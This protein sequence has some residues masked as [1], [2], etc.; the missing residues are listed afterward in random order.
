[1][2]A[3]AIRSA[4]PVARAPAFRSAPSA[5]HAAPAV[6]HAAPAR[7][8]VVPGS[9]RRGPAQIAGPRRGPE[10]AMARH[11]REASH[12]AAAETKQGA[13]ARGPREVTPNKGANGRNVAR[14]TPRNHDVAGSRRAPQLT[15]DRNA[16][17]RSS[18]LRNRAFA[19][20]S[21]RNTSTR[22]TFHGRFAERGVRF[23]DRHGSFGRRGVVLGWIGPVFW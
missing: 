3:P 19:A 6:R 17:I 15:G 9:G 5:H 22:A 10:R 13:N 11:G 7:P 8:S 23:A 18:V 20:S 4:P 12:G 2:P 14:G 16:A 21:A 1:R